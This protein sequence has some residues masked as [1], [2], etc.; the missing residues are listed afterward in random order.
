MASYKDIPK[1]MSAGIFQLH[2]RHKGVWDMQDF[3]ESTVNWLRERKWKFHERV[4]KHKH[5]SPFGLERQY[6]WMAEQDVDDYVNVR[7]DIYIHTYDARDLEAVDKEGNRRIFTKGKIWVI[8]KTSV[9]FDHEKRFM[10]NSFW[11]QLQKFYVTFII[12]KKIM[13]GYSPRYRHEL[14]AL[15]TFMM[16]KLKLETRDYEYANIAGVHQRG[17]R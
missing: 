15:H 10:K 9:N 6:V 3:Y 14:V 17:P 12:K 8:M 5:P 2:I 11:A 7:M 13:Q 16:R 4:Y 1:K